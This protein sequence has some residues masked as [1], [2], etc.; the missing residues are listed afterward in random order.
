MAA[1]ITSTGT[2]SARQTSQPTGQ[3]AGSVNN[4][5]SAVHRDTVENRAI[6]L[7]T[8]Y[9]T[10]FT[11]DVD[12]QQETMQFIGLMSDAYDI[13]A[14]VAISRLLQILNG[15]RNGEA[16]ETQRTYVP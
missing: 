10:N 14:P 1:T 2:W 13:A 12:G 9:R 7:A 15:A 6:N 5:S 11:A 3:G 16:V 4:E 8:N